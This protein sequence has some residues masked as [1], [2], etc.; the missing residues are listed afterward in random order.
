M[1][2]QSAK[3]QAAKHS[4]WGDFAECLLSGSKMQINEVVDK[5]MAIYAHS[6]VKKNS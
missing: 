2:I 1:T 6:Q 5:A 4:G 3:D